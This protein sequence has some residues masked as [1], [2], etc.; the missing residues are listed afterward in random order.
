[1][2]RAQMIALLG[3]LGVSFIS[4]AA[5]FF[6]GATETG[7]FIHT[8]R[9]QNSVLEADGGYTPENDEIKVYM[10]KVTAEDPDDGG[11]FLEDVGEQTCVRE[12]GGTTV[13][14]RQ[15]VRARCDLV[16][17]LDDGGTA[18]GGNVKGVYVIEARPV[19]G[20]ADDGG[21]TVNVALEVYGVNGAAKCP[22]VEKTSGF[23]QFVKALTCPVVKR[24]SNTNAL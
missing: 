3:A 4:G 10:T 6:D 17:N 13:E 11:L 12:D 5:F 15:W 14:I 18:P 9:I 8:L 1:M 21:V 2:T 24:R 22:A 19:P 23:K 20:E 16:I 7:Y